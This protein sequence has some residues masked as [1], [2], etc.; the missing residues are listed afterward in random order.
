[1]MIARRAALG[2]WLGCLLLGGSGPM[3]LAQPRVASV[4]ICGDLYALMLA[5]RSQIAAVSPEAGGPL[6]YY[7]KAAKGLPRNRGDLESLLAAHADLVL[8]EEGSKPQ[9]VR[10]LHRLGVKTIALPFSETFPEIANTI[11]IVADGLGQHQRGQAAAAAMMARVHRLEAARPA[12]DNRPIALFFRPDG[13]GS[14]AG[15]FMNSMVELAGFRNLQAMNGQTGWGAIPLETVVQN[16]PQIFITGFFDTERDALLATQG[17][18]LA[19]VT[20]THIPSIAL[21]GKDLVC[22]SPALVDGAEQAAAARRK[23]FAGDAR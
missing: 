13:G 19:V 14:G 11:Q 18:K 3:A 15:T 6:A 4:T 10:A 5:D 12:Y 16:P 21:P 17:S 7:P 8:L 9:L 20:R 23:L 2:L 1:M 22:P